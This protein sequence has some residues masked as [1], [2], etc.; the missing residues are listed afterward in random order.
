M[1]PFYQ[2]LVVIV[3]ALCLSAGSTAQAASRVL[4]CMPKRCCC[5]V[6]AH[7]FVDPI[8][9]SG[10]LHATDHATTPAMPMADAC[11]AQPVKQCCHME[12]FPYETEVAASPGAERDLV[13]SIM[14]MGADGL[15]EDSVLA[16]TMATSAV[17]VDHRLKIPLVPIY[18][19]LQS[20]LC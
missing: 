11:A 17:F 9:L 3:L 19:H 13:R 5:A 16:G 15:S 2:K 12:P 1:R 10:A 14:E 8:R 7:G 4:N 6:D 20:I 18:L